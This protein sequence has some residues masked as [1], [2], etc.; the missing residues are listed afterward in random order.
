[1]VYRGGIRYENTGLVIQN[2]SITDFAANLGLGLPLGGTFSN[3]NIGLEVGKRGTVYYNLVEEN[4]INLSIGLSLS[5]R[6]FVKRK[7]D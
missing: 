3:I 7:F 5:E 2:K 4:Y 6:W 1:M